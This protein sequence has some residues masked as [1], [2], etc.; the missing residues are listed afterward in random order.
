MEYTKNFETQFRPLPSIEDYNPQYID[1]DYGKDPYWDEEV[2]DKQNLQFRRDDYPPTDDEEDPEIRDNKLTQALI[3]LWQTNT[4]AM[5][6]E[7]EESYH[8]EDPQGPS[9]L[10]DETGFLHL[11][12]EKEG[13][14]SYVPF[15]TNLG[16]KF[17][18]RML[19]FTNGFWG[20][21][22]SRPN[23]HWGPLQCHTRNRSPENTP[24]D[25][26]IHSKG[27]T[28]SSFPN[29]G[30]KWGFRNPEKYRRTKVWKWRHRV[31]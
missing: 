18:R 29:D 9:N 26:S 11:L 30:R 3:E 17:K 27:G 25:A 12:V 10:L 24:F 13:E 7:I 16:L 31:P 23:R 6:S 1:P 28:C 21:N 14:P 22:L 15:S 2:Y 8:Q 4:E 20:A 19:Y 5:F